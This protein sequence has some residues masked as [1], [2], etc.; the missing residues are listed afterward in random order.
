MRNFNDQKQKIIVS[1]L[2]RNEDGQV[3]IVRSTHMPE[4]INDDEYFCIPSWEV[5][6]GISPKEKI[7]QELK[8]ILEESIQI[9][10]VN[11]TQSYL[12]ENDMTHV[13]EIVYNAMAPK[14]VCSTANTCESIN[15]INEDEIDSY[16]LSERLKVVLRKR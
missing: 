13:V 8:N 4:N 5:P 9:D 10:S 12:T 1:A 2:L 14:S 15:F 3:L 11:S 16:I 7:I 6:F